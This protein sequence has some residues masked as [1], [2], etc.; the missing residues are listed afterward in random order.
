MR[1][2]NTTKPQ[3][4][5]KKYEFYYNDFDWLNQD[6]D[7]SYTIQSLVVSAPFLYIQNELKILKDLKNE[8]KDLGFELLVQRDIDK[9]RVEIEIVDNYLNLEGKINFFPPIVV[10]LIPSYKTISE[11]KKNLFLHL[12]K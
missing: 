11:E 6:T 4:L 3:T 1:R 2:R 5:S 10:A 7:R 8:Y 12:K 9:K